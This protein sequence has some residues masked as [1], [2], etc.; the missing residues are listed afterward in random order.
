MSNN[1]KE[2]F[3]MAKLDVMRTIDNVR[4]KINPHYDLRAYHMYRIVEISPT[5]FELI[6][7]AFNFGYVQGSKAERMKQ[8]ISR[9]GV[10]ID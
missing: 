1:L 2:V 3:L 5:T 9:G 10:K 4:E 6:G 7:N 8:R